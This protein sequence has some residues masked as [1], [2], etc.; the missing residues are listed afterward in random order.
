MNK[1]TPNHIT[2]KFLKNSDKDN[3]LKA[4]RQKRHIYRGPVIR[5][6]ANFSSKQCKCEDSEAIFLKY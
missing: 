6:I 5:M 3:I 4:A 1:P 2:N